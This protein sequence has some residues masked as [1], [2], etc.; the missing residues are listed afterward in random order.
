[1]KT[2]TRFYT[3]SPCI[4]GENRVQCLL[5]IRNKN[6][7]NKG[8]NLFHLN[9]RVSEYCLQNM[10]LYIFSKVIFIKN[11]IDKKAILFEL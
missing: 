1:M 4:G 10:S 9:D 8:N 5:S 6:N 2:K 3:K 7:N 11:N